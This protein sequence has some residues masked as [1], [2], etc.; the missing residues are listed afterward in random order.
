[1]TQYGTSGLVASA[2]F[3]FELC[4]S[5]ARDL[6]AL[7]DDTQENER[8]IAASH[9]DTLVDFTGPKL[10]EFVT[11]RDQDA[12]AAG[13]VITNLEATARSLAEQWAGQRGNQDRINHAAWVAEQRSNEG[14]LERGTNWLLSRETD[15]GAPPE[16]PPVPQPPRFEATRAPIHG[17]FE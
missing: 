1:M 14:W 8:R 6:W 17:R 5:A 9:S 11:R 4:L 10:R 15:Y 13:S 2:N 7:I 16:D 12:T 3:P